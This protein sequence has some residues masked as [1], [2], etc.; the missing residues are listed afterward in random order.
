MSRLPCLGGGPAVDLADLR[1]PA[2]VNFWATY[3]GPCRSEAPIFERG[4][5]TSW[6]TSSP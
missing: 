4:S 3:C 5:N 1:G 6:V 2:V